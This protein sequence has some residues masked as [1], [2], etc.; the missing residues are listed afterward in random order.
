MKLLPVLPL[1][2][3]AP[4]LRAAPL[5]RDLGQG[6]TYWRAHAIPEDLPATLA[7]RPCVLDV[8]YVH[9]GGE[10]GAELLA[11]LRTHAGPHAPVFLL[12]NSDT[13]GALLSPLNSPDSVIGLVIIGPR[14]KD[15]EPD[16]GVKEKAEEERKAYEA[17]EHGASVDS[18]ITRRVDK[19]RNDEA[20]LEKAR[21]DENG[22]DGDGADERKPAAAAKPAPAQ[23]IDVSLQRA[24]Q[25]DRALLALRRLP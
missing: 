1:L 6:L 16:I 25:L 3:L 20:T 11:W 23:L 15:F 10:Q 12:A 2:A 19:V 14:T 5:E 8:R 7:H 9:G 22:D 24:V 21:A 17:L 18:L 13:S 4:G